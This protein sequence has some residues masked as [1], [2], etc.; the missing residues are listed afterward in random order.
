MRAS[1]LF[2]FVVT[3][4]VAAPQDARADQKIK[5]NQKAEVYARRGE[6]AKVIVTLEKGAAMKML[7]TQGRWVQVRVKGRTGWVPRSVVD[8]PDEGIARNTRR[9]P[10]VDGRGTKRGFG[11]ESGPDDRVGADA[12]GEGEGDGGDDDDDADDAPPPK[13]KTPPPKPKT[14]ATKGG[15]KDVPDDDDDDDDDDADADDGD[16]A[17]ADD[18]DVSDEPEDSEPPRKTVRVASKTSVYSEADEES[19]VEFTADS[20]M[21]LY[22]TGN[23][24]GKYTEVENDEGD[25]GYVLTDEL[26]VDEDSDDAPGKRVRH[27]D[28]KARLGVTIM[29]QGMRTANGGEGLPNNYNLTT[30]AAT[31]ALGGTVLFPWKERLVVGGEMAFDAA[32]NTG[33]TVMAGAPATK[34]KLYNLNARAVLGYDLRKKSGMMVFGRLGLRYE[35]FQVS[36]VGDLTKNVGKIPSEIVTAP[37]IGAALALP[38]LT[39]KIGLRFSIDTVLFGASVKQTKRLED[40]ANPS[41]K[42]ALIGTGLT[43]A[44]KKTFFIQATYDLNFFRKSFGA[45]VD[46]SNR[47]HMGMASARTDVFHQATVGVARAF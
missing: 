16:D 38:R 29:Q 41:A 36:D 31:I 30:S 42:G 13:G 19:D 20:K 46:G 37:S 1:I 33:I 39:E 27:I 26:E 22:P 35:S 45:P 6:Q 47:Q 28:A 2:L 5:T 12:V 23:R 25:I 18:A 44:W 3:A 15:G 43:Y 40:G 34:I 11:G 21:A 7:K 8:L 10:F 24:Q 17:D 32:A 9:R 4:L 14:V